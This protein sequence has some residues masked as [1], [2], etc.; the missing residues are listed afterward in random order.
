M[1]QIE[2]AHSLLKENISTIGNVS[3]WAYKMGFKKPSKFSWEYRKKYGVRPS[4]V[5]I[6][7]KTEKVIE[8]INKHPEE[9]NYCICLEFGFAHEKALYKFLKRHTGKSPT[10]LRK[11]ITK[12]DNEKGYCF[13]WF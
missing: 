3:E 8:Y 13:H 12:K 5:L 7:I 6:D 11:R 10:E 9:K 2:K 1:E 4:D